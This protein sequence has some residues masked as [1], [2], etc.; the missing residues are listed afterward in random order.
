MD[1]HILML[2]KGLEFLDTVVIHLREL[3]EK[4]RTITKLECQAPHLTPLL[5]K[6]HIYVS[7]LHYGSEIFEDSVSW[8]QIA[9]G[10]VFEECLTTLLGEFKEKTV[11]CD[12]LSQHDDSRKFR[13][14]SIIAEEIHSLGDQLKPPG[15]SLVNVLLDGQLMATLDPMNHLD[16]YGAL[17]RFFVWHNA[18]TVCYESHGCD[19][20]VL[21]NWVHL[22]NGEIMSIHEKSFLCPDLWRGSLR[23]TTNNKNTS[24]DIPGFSLF[25]SP[26]LERSTNHEMENMNIKTIQNKEKCPEHKEKVPVPFEVSSCLE[27]VHICSVD[28]IPLHLI[29]HARF[30]L[31]VKSFSRFLQASQFLHHVNSKKKVAVI[32]RLKLADKTLLPKHDISD[33]FTSKAWKKAVLCGS[34]QTPVLEIKGHTKYLNFLLVS[35]YPVSSSSVS[36]YPLYDHSTQDA[37]FY[38]DLIT[39]CKPSTYNIEHARQDIKTHLK[40]IP[41]MS[42]TS[43]QCFVQ[44]LESVQKIVKNQCTDNEKEVCQTENPPDNDLN[45]IHSVVLQNWEQTRLFNSASLPR[46]MKR[47][48][49][50]FDELVEPSSWP[51]MRSLYQKESQNKLSLP[52]AKG[53]T[54]ASLPDAKDFS[55]Y[56]QSD[57]RP[58]SGRLEVGNHKCS[59]KSHI[60]FEE[61]QKMKWPNLKH[62]RYHDVYYN[63]DS[64]SDETQMELNKFKDH[65]ILQETACNC[66]SHQVAQVTVM[67]QN[68]NETKRKMNF[69]LEKHVKGNSYNKSASSNTPESEEQNGSSEILELQKR[70]RKH[71]KFVASK[72]N[73]QLNSSAKLSAKVKPSCSNTLKTN[74]R[75]PR[76]QMNSKP[77]V[78]KSD[79]VKQ[80]ISSDLESRCV[81]DGFNSYS[82]KDEKT[83]SSHCLHCRKI[84]SN[85]TSLHQYTLNSSSRTSL[86]TDSELPDKHKRKLREAVTCAL[87]ANGIPMTHPSF[88]ACGKKL[89]AVC[90][91]FAKDV[92]GHGRTSTMLK[93]ISNAH[94]KQV[95]EFERMKI[96]KT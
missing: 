10:S 40:C 79:F 51:E 43:F 1:T 85:A 27:V 6:D 58:V 34:V 2:C 47:V 8:K 95:I 29:C 50:S 44:L 33:S 84:S 91:T 74:V 57:G 38:H 37:S 63:I 73:K 35:D 16:L 88:R 3:V 11:H 67:G 61:L 90:K 83:Y 7:C 68:E 75:S 69:K 45:T 66:N 89:F 28:T 72:I 64:T 20:Q 54:E 53:I 32:L 21:N 42:D 5:K 60:S 18:Y 48:F 46:K 94:V 25:P 96:S 62:C 24:L 4:L 65:Y 59:S 17:Y 81:A 80:N 71:G 39:N 86:K 56:F 19:K 41:E 55:K 14:I 30:C 26:E 93:K 9:L 12:V 92:I 36:V 77:N 82:R 22:L 49:A 15:N 87:E 78:T 70:L 76:K 13:T 52:G 31:C 23:F